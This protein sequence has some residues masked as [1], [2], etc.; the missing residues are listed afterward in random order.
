VGDLPAVLMDL[1]S[2]ARAAIDHLVDL[3]HL[4]L[5]YIGGPRNSWT[6]RELR[7]AAVA[8][9][10]ARG[11]NLTLLAYPS[12]DSIAVGLTTRPYNIPSRFMSVVY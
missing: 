6:N 2:G 7:R 10:R 9:A 12:V 4:E 8:A 11:A 1:A 3:G 5:A